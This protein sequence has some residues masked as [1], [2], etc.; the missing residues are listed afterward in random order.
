MIRTFGLCAF[1]IGLISLGSTPALAGE[2]AF[3]GTGMGMALGGYLGSH[4]GKGSG[5]LAATGAGVFLGGM[6]GHSMGQ[7]LDRADA[8]YYRG[9]V[10][11]T[12]SVYYGPAYPVYQPTYVAPSAPQIVY[13]PV[14][15]YTPRRAV[16][17]EENYL[18]PQPSLPCR[19]FTQTIMIGGEPH[20][21]F[22]HACLRPDGSWQIT[23]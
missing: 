18:G 13:Q 20:E 23:P 11:R 19:T 14:E 2:K 7:S 17:V 21:S 4:I 5:Q 9:G 1:V 6:M 3:W 16:Y 15:V 10:G 12:G 8:A 22:G